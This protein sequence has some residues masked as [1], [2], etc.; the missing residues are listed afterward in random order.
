MAQ[1][2]DIQITFDAES[3]LHKYPT[4]SLKPEAP[5]AVD[6][7]Y[8][9]M[10]VADDEAVSGNG[11]G[12]LNVRAETNDTIR[13]RETTPGTD[14]STILYAFPTKTDL[15][16]VPQPL[17]VPVQAPLP[18]P[19]NPT[20]PKTQTIQDYYWNCVVTK[21]SPDPKVPLAYHFNFMIVSRHGAT[22]GYYSWD[23]WITITS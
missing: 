8:I 21:P 20:K 12:N 18:D 14:Y 11:G 1:T 13:W 17:L 4:P 15:I 7:K 22:K 9:F 3:I 6:S 10:V 5:T 2:I 23:P 16:S 19:A